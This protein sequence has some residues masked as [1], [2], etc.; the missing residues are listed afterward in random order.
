MKKKE[1]HAPRLS[2]KARAQLR[3][4]T[5]WPNGKP[6]SK[7]GSKRTW[8][9]PWNRLAD[10]AGGIDAL[11]A[12]LYSTRRQLQRWAVEGMKP[13]SQAQA[14]I[15]QTAKALG[16]RSPFEHDAT[17]R[18]GVL[19]PLES[20]A[21]LKPRFAAAVR[22]TGL[23]RAQLAARSA[24]AARSGR[25]SKGVTRVRNLPSGRKRTNRK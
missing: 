3:A 15:T 17:D 7:T 1:D 24:V 18:T 2:K 16:V 9:G 25:E 14:L 4:V 22:G 23:E 6:G 5:A 12:L 20:N 13:S 11:A 19:F 10:A 8:E 21:T